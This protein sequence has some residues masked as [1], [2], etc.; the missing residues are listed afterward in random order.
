MNSPKDSSI[1][2]LLPATGTKVP[3]EGCFN[4]KQNIF[5]LKHSK[6]GY[7]THFRVLILHKYKKK[8]ILQFSP[9]FFE[10]NFFLYLF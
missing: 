8:K 6:E 7:K 5:P 9:S 4:R 3:G 10:H 2:K 1:L